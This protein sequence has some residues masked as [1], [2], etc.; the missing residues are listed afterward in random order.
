MFDSVTPEA[1]PSNANNLAGYVDGAFQTIPYLRKHW[2]NAHH[3]LPI[4]VFGHTAAHCLDVEVSDA[5]P[6]DAVDW[7][8]DRHQAG[9]QHPKVYA[10][11]STW[12]QIIGFIEKARMPRDRF[13]VWTAHPTGVA[14]LCGP[15]CFSG[16]KYRSDSTQFDWHAL[17]RNL[18]ES[19]FRDGFFD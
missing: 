18:D 19:I 11:L 12:V 10:N 6:S 3:I 17:G 2:P 15:E 16:F 4:T 8:H 1:I 5:S 9:V 14:H 7:I 13:R